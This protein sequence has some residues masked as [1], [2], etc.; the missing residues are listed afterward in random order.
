MDPLAPDDHR[1]V[2][3]ADGW[4]RLGDVAPAAAELAS[5][6]VGARGHPDFLQV[7]WTLASRR[8]EWGECLRLAEQ[9][10]R[11]APERR[12]GWLHLP[13]SLHRL[14]RTAE[15]YDRLL[16]AADRFEPG[17]TVPFLLARFACVLGR[18]EVARRW[19]AA[20]FRQAAMEENESVLRRRVEEEPDLEGIRGDFGAG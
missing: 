2:Q 16:A 8:G 1:R 11:L 6:S 20:A 19:L 14:G 18:N 17:S 13:L 12:F 9:L 15:A 5:V 3:A 10:V 7:N 4:L